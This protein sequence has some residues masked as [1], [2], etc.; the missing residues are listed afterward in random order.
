MTVSC[1]VER[2]DGL[3]PTDPFGDANPQEMLTVKVFPVE[4]DDRTGELFKGDEVARATE[5]VTRNREDSDDVVVTYE[6][7]NIST[8]TANDRG[9]EYVMQFDIQSYENHIPE[10]FFWV[11][12]YSQELELCDEQHPWFIGPDEV[13]EGVPGIGLVS[14]Q[15]RY[16]DGVGELPE[17][18]DLSNIDVPGGLVYLTDEEVKAGEGLIDFRLVKT[19]DG[20]FLNAHGDQSIAGFAPLFGEFGPNGVSVQLESNDENEPLYGIYSILGS[21][22]RSLVEQVVSG[23][24]TTGEPFELSS[25]LDLGL[26]PACIEEALGSYADVGSAASCNFDWDRLYLMRGADG[27]FSVIEIRYADIFE[28]YDG[29][30]RA[31]VDLGFATVNTVGDLVIPKPEFDVGSSHHDGDILSLIHISE[32]TRPY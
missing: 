30:H 13:F 6:L 27:Q 25:S 11:D 4:F 15:T 7:A 12:G 19:A 10:L 18:V 22:V 21:N 2:F 32:P 8:G 28:E 1:A 20:I 24:T 31:F 26:S 14:D 3:D 29:S 17:G 16:Y 23:E 5:G 9:R